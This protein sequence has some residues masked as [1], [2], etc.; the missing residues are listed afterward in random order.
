[1][2]IASD[3]VLANMRSLLLSPFEVGKISLPFQTDR[4]WENYDID[5]LEN[6]LNGGYTERESKIFCPWNHSKNTLF[7]NENGIRPKYLENFEI[8]DCIKF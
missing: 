4:N 5:Q 8:L 6:A 1:M 7:L 2:H 3:W